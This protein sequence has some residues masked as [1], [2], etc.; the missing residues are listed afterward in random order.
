MFVA[1][2]CAIRAA[3]TVRDCEAE[4]CWTRLAARRT[5]PLMADNDTTNKDI[6][7]LTDWCMHLEEELL[8]LKSILRAAGVAI[9]S[10]D[11]STGQPVS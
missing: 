6:E 2:G 9:A 3:R 5:T 7:R 1:A 11:M 4:C 8:R 10:A